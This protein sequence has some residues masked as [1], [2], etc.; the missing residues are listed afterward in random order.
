MVTQHILCYCVNQNNS[1]VGMYYFL[2]S[3]SYYFPQHTHLSKF[4]LSV[5]ELA[6]NVVMVIFSFVLHTLSLRMR[7][8][9]K[10][11]HVSMCSA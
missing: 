1:N 2:A 6:F 11:E 9:F 7:I 5:N 3:L 8:L 4:I 10:D